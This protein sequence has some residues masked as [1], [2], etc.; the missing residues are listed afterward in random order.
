MGKNKNLKKT[1]ALVKGNKVL[2]ATLGGIAIGV[3][4]AAILGIDKAKKIASSIG[5]SSNQLSGK[6]PEQV[7][8]DRQAFPEAAEIKSWKTT[9]AEKN[10]S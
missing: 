10:L 3:S 7:A 2:L 5:D 6:I 4:L 1:G 8:A 9:K